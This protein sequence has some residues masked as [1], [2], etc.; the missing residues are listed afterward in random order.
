MPRSLKAFVLLSLTGACLGRPASA[1]PCDEV[2]MN[3]TEGGVVGSKNLKV[4][5]AERRSDRWIAKK[6]HAVYMCPSRCDWRR[7]SSGG[8]SSAATTVVVPGAVSAPARDP[9]GRLGPT[10]APLRDD[11][12]VAAL[13]RDQPAAR[14]EATLLPAG[15]PYA[16]ELEAAAARYRLPSHLLRAVLHV[17]SGGN[18]L[19]VSH[20]GAQGLMQLIP[21]TAQAMG[22]SDPHDPAQSIAGGARFLRVLANRFQ[23]DLVKVLAAYHAGS[24]RVQGRDATPFAATDDYVRKILKLYY[25]F[26]DQAAPLRDGSARRSPG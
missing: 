5:R 22:V 14:A 26:R 2:V 7:S 12:P 13:P 16:A 24:T 8:G 20:K 1:T 19:A 9:R 3:C 25:Q 23:G 10:P 11:G 15:T 4:L 18:P 21:A 17:E 6:C